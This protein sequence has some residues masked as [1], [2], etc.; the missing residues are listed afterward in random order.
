[1]AAKSEYTRGRVHAYKH[2]DNGRWYVRFVHQNRREHFS[3]KVTRRTLAEKEANEINDLLESGQWSKLRNRAKARHRTFADVT[4]EYLEKGCRWSETTL[5]GCS[6]SLN[7][8]LSEF[9]DLAVTDIDA[10]IIESYIAR[11]RDEGRSKGTRNRE[12]A[13]VK[14]ILKKAFEW[15][16]VPHNAAADVTTERQGK[17]TPQPYTRD[18]L[19]RLLAELQPQHRSIATLYLHTALR[20]GELMK[21]MWADVDWEARTLT[22]RAPKNDDDRTIPLSQESYTIL[23]GRRKVWEGERRSGVVDLRV[24]GESGDIR[25]VLDRAAVRAQIDEGRRHRLQHRLRDTC[26]TT[27]LDAAVPLDRVQ[28]ILGHRDIGMT[29]RYAETRPEALRE[30][31]AATFDR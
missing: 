29:R 27:L 10:G 9:G 3:L 11:R 24:Y 26:A 1:M 7:R 16:Y 28:L 12:L 21:L 30:A 22:V 6:S 13:I 5:K 15:G 18:E 2:P 19:S 31:I 17:K 23:Q 4:T 25:K 20:R 8:L 14:A